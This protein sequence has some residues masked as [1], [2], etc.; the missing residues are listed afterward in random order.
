MIQDIF[1]PEK[2]GTYY[3]FSQRMV[4]INITKAHL[5][6]TI[7]VARGSQITIEKSMV[8]PLAGEKSD[9][10]ERIIEAIKKVIQKIGSTGNIRIALS[11]NTV[12]F[13]EL[14]LPFDEYDK[15]NK[16]VRFEVEPLLPFTAQDAI[17]DFIITD[18]STGNGAQVLVAAAQKQTIAEQLSLFEQAGIDPAV[19]TVDAFCLYALYHQIPAYKAVQGTAI[20]IDLDLPFTKILIIHNGQLRIIRTLPH[21]VAQIAKSASEPLKMSVQQV[22]DHLIRFGLEK[23]EP[24]E[25][26]QTLQ[27]SF[28]DFWDKTQ[29]ALN[30]ALNQLNEHKI[31]QIILT[32]TGAEIK[33]ISA[34]VQE[35]AQSP[36]ELFDIKKLTQNTQYHIASKVEIPQ[37]S[38]VSVGAALPSPVTRHF[39][40]RRGAFERV[41]TILL[42]KQFI[43]AGILVILLFGVLI[44]HSIIQ[45]KKLNTEITTSQEETIEQLKNR[46]TAIPEEEDDL[47][48][49]LQEA[50][51]QLTKEEN[52][53]LAFSNQTRA[54][55]LEYLLELTSR[56]NKQELGFTPEQIIINDGAKGE[57][58]VNGKVR[59]YE[60]LKLLEQSLSKSKI[61]SYEEGPKTPTFSLKMHIRRTREQ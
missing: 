32:G 44:T 23:S 24:P 50:K 11:A 21:G 34:F 38:M 8:E 22:M 51:A 27:K 33:G 20:I 59:D 3:L 1:L 40:L 31:T 14:R 60:A 15:L 41:N 4:G 48:E 57:V 53:W 19:I 58:T 25:I 5:Y 46:F 18:A 61:F 2:F 12:V 42:L 26:V 43:T 36:C 39:N 45:T 35:K 28:G 6:V 13:K 54:S 30:S 7:V 16:I 9:P 37:A 10:T 56:I 17:V 49:V 52:I 29:F 55:F 47:D